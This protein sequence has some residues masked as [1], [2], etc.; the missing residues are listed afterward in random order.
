MQNKF[1]WFNLSK[2]LPFM[3]TWCFCYLSIFISKRVFGC[4]SIFFKG[5]WKDLH[6]LLPRVVEKKAI[7]AAYGKVEEGSLSS[8]CAAVLCT[9]LVLHIQGPWFKPYLRRRMEEE[10]G[11]QN[12]PSPRRHWGHRSFRGCFEEATAQERRYR[13]SASSFSISEKATYARDHQ[14]KGELQKN[15]DNHYCGTGCEK[16]FSSLSITFIFFKEVQIG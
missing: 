9:C 5:C 15:R 14:N 4:Y 13:S 2:G 3:H 1:N 7:L 11:E 12:S 6:V 16:K 8:L 10:W